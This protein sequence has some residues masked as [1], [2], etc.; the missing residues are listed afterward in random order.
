MLIA[1]SL[2]FYM[3]QNA[4]NKRFAVICPSTPFYNVM[5]IFF[6]FAGLAVIGFLKAVPTGVFLLSAAY[7]LVYFISIYLL[8]YAMKKGPLS[9]TTLVF[10]LGNTIA[11]LYGIIAYKEPLTGFTVLGICFMTAVTF[12]CMPKAEKGE[13]S[14]KGWFIP[15]LAGAVGN[16]ILG[17]IK[18]SMTASFPNIG[19]GEFLAWAFIFGAF[20]GGIYCAVIYFK[21]PS[22][23]PKI[24]L[25]GAM[26]AV[27]SGAGTAGGNLFFMKALQSGLSSAIAFP[28]HTGLLT[29]L[30]WIMSL[31]LFRDV[32]FRLRYAAAIFSCIAGM[33]LIRM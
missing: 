13:K 26:C 32:K 18:K 9:L 10:N 29:L 31:L 28:L 14:K 33:I 30:L 15:S 12:L 2:F 5:C 11:C 3:I 23:L 16:G 4:A 24:S 21:T 27:L 1:L 7:G 19:S 6:A 25:R 20:I 22:A 17:C 8:V